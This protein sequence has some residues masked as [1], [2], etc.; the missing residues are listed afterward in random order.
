MYLIWCSASTLHTWVASLPH[1]LHPKE[2]FRLMK[3]IHNIGALLQLAHSS[4]TQVQRMDR[5]VWWR[6]SKRCSVHRPMKTMKKK[7]PKIRT[8]S[9]QTHC[10]RMEVCAFY[11]KVSFSSFSPFLGT[12]CIVITCYL[13]MHTFNN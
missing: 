4:R 6:H 10:P 7:Q 12:A 11:L 8:N 13:Y 5:R 9:L 1:V 2:P 3:T